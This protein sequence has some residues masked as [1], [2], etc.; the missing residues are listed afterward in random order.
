MWQAH[1]GAGPHWGPSLSL[2][3]ATNVDHRSPSGAPDPGSVTVVSETDH[4]TFKLEGVGMG[5]DG[6]GRV[7]ASD[8]RTVWIYRHKV[9]D[10]I[11]LKLSPTLYTRLN[12]G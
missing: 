6:C 5:T 1:R 7:C 2:S 10:L 11:V 12:I 3:E 4:C 9:P 8:R